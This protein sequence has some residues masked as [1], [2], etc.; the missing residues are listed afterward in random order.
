MSQTNW[1]SEAQNDLGYGQIFAMLWRRRLWFAG[2][3]GGVLAIAIPISLMKEPVFQSYTQ[4]LVESNY[5][6]KGFTSKVS[7][8]SLEQEF[9][10]ATIEIDYATQLKVLKSSEI[11]KRVVDRLGW[12]DSE[13][14]ETE[15]IEA[16]RRS[17]VVS[18]VVEEGSSANEGETSIIQAM[19]TGSSPSETKRVLEVIQKVYLEYNLEQQEKRLKEGLTFIEQQIPQAQNDLTK[20]EAALTALSK[21][22]NLI[23]PEQEAIALKEN[24]RNIAQEREILK[25]QSNQTIGNYTTLQQQLGLSAENSLALSRLS[26]SARYQN[27]LNKLQEIE[28]NLAT[29]Q[30]KFTDE[31]PIIQN[32]IDQRDSQRTLLIKEAKKVLGKLPGNFLP[33]D[34]ESIEKQRQ[35]FDSDNKFNDQIT[36][37]QSNITGIRERDLSLAKTEAELRQRLV[38]FPELIAQYR[39]LTQEAEIKREALQRL[40]QAKQ[41][42]E[43]EL[44]RGGFNWQI[45]EP[46]QLGVQIAPSLSQDLLLS[47]VVAS[48]LG[49]TVAFFKESIDERIND[50]KEI[51]RK[52]SLPVLGTT[53]GLSL[54]SSN[55]FSAQLPF[56]SNSHLTTDIKEV[57]QW[58]PFRESL[59]VIYENIQLSNIALSLKSLAIT[60]AIAGEGKSTFILGLALS[61]ARHRQRVLVIDA[62][63]RCPSLHKP[64]NL[65]NQSGLADCLSGEIEHPTI[66]EVSFL[67]E[68]INLIS[69]GS[70]PQDPVKLLSSSK[71]QNLIDQYKQNYDLI[72]VDTPPAIGMVD[73]IR[74]ASICDSTVLMMRLDKVKASELIEAE[75]LLSKLNVLGIVANDSKQYETQS[76][77]LLPQPA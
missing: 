15:I 72:L 49:G 64:F 67:G 31:N 59:D 4:V 8:Q 38:Q 75:A 29:E 77:F 12:E 48:F 6:A 52:T 76:Q 40:L 2:V 36:E 22:H 60:S 74:V 47:L 41:E 46:P 19:Y 25:A 68:T 16:L 18:Q 45:I 69:S 13:K 1:E 71:F 9:V 32:L 30:T 43:I 51:G 5:Q 53:P 28:I 14:T 58:Q 10:D 11:L 70:K 73:A 17:L 62:D 23:S 57:I 56:S 35:F 44:N 54:S 21:E 33:V 7:D 66:E 20:A 37:S 65:S 61:V 27:L 50:P 3:F 34:L 39:S 55:L 24:I 42:L 26:Q 63:L